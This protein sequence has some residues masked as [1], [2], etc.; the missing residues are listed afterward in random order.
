LAA[1]DGLDLTVLYAATVRPFD[2]A[3]L[4]E[5]LTAPDVIL[6]EPY[7]AGTSAAEVADALLHV[8]HR[9]LSLGVPRLELRRYGTP[10]EH[11]AAYGL[12]AVG[13]RRSFVSFLH[14]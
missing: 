4:A 8:P 5:T 12:D 14:G 13:L 11:D 9:L 6:V 7:A 1:S 2:K 10:A 3:T